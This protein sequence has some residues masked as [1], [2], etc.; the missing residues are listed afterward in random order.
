MATTTSTAK[1]ART[2]PTILPLP[3]TTEAA[4]DVLFAIAPSEDN[5]LKPFLLEGFL[6]VAGTDVSE[7]GFDAP[8]VRP[9]RAALVPVEG[10]GAA[11]GRAGLAP[12][13][14]FDVTEGREDFLRPDD[15]R[16]ASRR[17]D[18]WSVEHARQT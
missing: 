8:S 13:T 4:S 18:D 5:G 10:L 7:R 17:P 14:G 2:P 6:A 11:M 12:I 1:T 16:A 9:G 15:Y 3:V